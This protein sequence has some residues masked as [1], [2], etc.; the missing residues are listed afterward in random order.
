VDAPDARVPVDQIAVGDAPDASRPSV[1]HGPG[2]DAPTSIDGSG[3]A[4]P[5]GADG[6]SG[7]PAGPDQ[8]AGGTRT[9][10]GGGSQSATTSG[11][12][13]DAGADG[14]FDVKPEETPLGGITTGGS[15]LGGRHDGLSYDTVPDDLGDRWG[16]D[17][18]APP[19]QAT[20]DEM[21][22]I[23]TF[24]AGAPK[25]AIDNAYE[26]EGARGVH[27]ALQ[28]MLANPAISDAAKE[29]LAN[30]AADKVHTGAGGSTP[31]AGGGGGATE[32][33]AGPTVDPEPP[34][35]DDPNWQNYWQ[36]RTGGDIDWGDT[37]EASV[38]YEPGTLEDDQIDYGEDYE[39]PEADY[40]QAP[41]DSDTG[42]IDPA[43]V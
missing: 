13:G 25:A 30:Y 1:E 32:D 15:D 27:N 20:P 4:G 39:P 35:P 31:P 3:Q 21:T 16:I 11:R 8:S 10:S 43:E 37:T 41:T 17:T 28:D 7:G 19:E 26:A 5:P 2:S 38:D 29:Q 36:G 33:H 42:D 34:D 40:D 22:G 9:A 18:D 24:G 6:A 14:P 23:D 12:G